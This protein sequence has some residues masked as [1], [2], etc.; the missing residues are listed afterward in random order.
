[1]LDMLGYGKG[2]AEIARVLGYKTPKA[3]ANIGDRVFDKILSPQ[4]Q[5]RIAREGIKKRHVAL[6]IWQSRRSSDA[7]KQ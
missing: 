3:A 6:E 5:E 2:W 4:D 1:M 7:L